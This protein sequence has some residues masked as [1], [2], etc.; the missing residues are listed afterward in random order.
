MKNTGRDKMTLKKNT[1]RLLM[2]LSI[3]V[4]M[5]AA[6]EEDPESIYDPDVTGGETPVVSSVVPDSNY[7]SEDVTFSGVGVVQIT[8]ENFSPVTDHNIVFFDG[9]PGE[10]IS[11]TTTL[12]IV[13][14]PD[15]SGDSVEVKISVQGAFHFGDYANPYK[16]TPALHEIGGFDDLDQLYAVACDETETLWITAFGVP[17]ISIIAVEP[18]SLKET[19][20]SSLTVASTSFKYGGKD[21][22]F[23]TGGAILYAMNRQTESADFSALFTINPSDITKD[24]DFVDS[25]LAFVAIKKA[26]NLGYIMSA[27]MEAVSMDTA[28]AYD[29]LGIESIRIFDNELYVAGS[30][31]IGGVNQPSVIWKNSIIGNSLGPKQFVLDLSDYPE[32]GSAQITAITFSEDGKMYIGLNLVSA[33]LQFDNGI[34]QPF[35]DP[36]LSPPTKDLTWGNGEYLYQLKSNRMIKINMVEVG[37]AYGGRF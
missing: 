9:M 14:V 3:L 22:L 10:V 8:G 21:R 20:F 5:M 25:T 31:L 35:Y 15:V 16:I 37:A 32:Y 26:P 36:I 33:I 23:M 6:C 18:D 13:R 34:L 17:T 29:S 27:D 19:R 30:Y 2:L 1:P 28:T 7:N 11:S 4:L 12:L 24:V